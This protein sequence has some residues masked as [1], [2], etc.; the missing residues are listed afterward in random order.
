MDGSVVA[1]L[2][3]AE[4]RLGAWERWAMGRAEAESALAEAHASNRL[5]CAGGAAACGGGSVRTP[6]HGM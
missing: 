1:A 6:P 4:R 3:L 2:A 5:A